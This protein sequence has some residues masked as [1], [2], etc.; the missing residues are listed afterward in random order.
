MIT[1][2]VSDSGMKRALAAS[3][4]AVTDGQTNGRTPDRYSNVTALDADSVIK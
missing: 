4:R 3:S 2:C 1:T